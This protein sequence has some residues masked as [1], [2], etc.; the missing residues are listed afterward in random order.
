MNEMKINDNNSRIINGLSVDVED[1]FQVSNFTNIAH[2]DQWDNYELRVERNT[3]R[4]LD[5]FD[6]HNA[7]ATFFILGWIAER[8]PDVVK[9]IARRGHEVGSHGY[10]HQLVYELTPEEFRDDLLKTNDILTALTGQKIH[11]YRAPSYSITRANQWALSVLAKCGFTYDSSIFPIHHHRYGI[12]DFSRCA[13]NLDLPDGLTLRELPISTL[14]FGNKNFPVGGGAY[15]RLL[16]YLFLKSAYKHLN[17]R[18]KQPF[19]FYFHPWEIDSGQPR[20]KC[21]R[22]TRLRHYGG[23]ASF[24]KKLSKLLSDFSFQPLKNI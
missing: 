7:K 1:Y 8:V 6:A 9:E 18:E 4:L 16:P 17:N 24:E 13:I 21:S 23:I 3:L 20:M 22:F 5:L 19:I 14:K 2:Y 12:P 15:A 11:G 10:R